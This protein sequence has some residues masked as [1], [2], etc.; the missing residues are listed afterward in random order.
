M[1]NIYLDRIVTNNDREPS[2][3]HAT[4]VE[5]DEKKARQNAL[6]DWKRDTRGVKAMYGCSVLCA[7]TLP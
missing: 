2:A 6:K 3:P 4:A 1:C 7:L 5:F